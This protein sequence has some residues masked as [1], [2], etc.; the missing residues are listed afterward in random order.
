[1]KSVFVLLSLLVIIEVMGQG[2]TRWRGPDANGI[3][4]DKGLLKQWPEDG[5]EQ[6][7]KF[8]QLG[9]GFSSPAIS[10]GFIYIPTMIDQ[11]GYMFKLTMDGELVWKKKYGPEFYESYPGAR[12]TATIVENRL[13]FLSFYVWIPV[14]G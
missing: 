5:P 12:A 4:P 13:Y 8:E 1:M 9:E 14:T 11:M 2:P 10:N 7:W 3:Y 6:L